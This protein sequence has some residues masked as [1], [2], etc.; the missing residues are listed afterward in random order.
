MVFI[1]KSWYPYKKKTCKRRFL[2]LAI[3]FL[4]EY[5]DFYRAGHQFPGSKLFT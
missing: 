3:A 4:L 5:M 2:Y 1:A